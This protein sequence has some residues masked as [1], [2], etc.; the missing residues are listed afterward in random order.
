MKYYITENLT[1]TAGVRDYQFTI[2]GCH[3]TLLVNGQVSF[4]LYNMD[5]TVATDIH[6]QLQV[7]GTLY[8]NI[9]T[10]FYVKPGQ[11][12]LN[13]GGTSQLSG[14]LCYQKMVDSNDINYKLPDDIS[15]DISTG[16]ANSIYPANGRLCTVEDVFAEY[17]IDNEFYD[18]GYYL[19]E[20]VKNQLVTYEM[21]LKG[22]S[23]KLLS[24]VGYENINNN[25]KNS[26]FKI[27]KIDPTLSEQE[28]TPPK[29]FFNEILNA[30]KE[31]TSK[32]LS[33]NTTYDI[34]RIDENTN[35]YDI[36]SHTLTYKSEGNNPIITD[37]D[38]SSITENLKYNKPLT[39]ES[40]KE[41]F[42]TLIGNDAHRPGIQCSL[43]S[44]LDYISF[45][46][47][48]TT[49]N[50]GL[51]TLFPNMLETQYKTHQVNNDMQFINVQGTIRNGIL[52][53]TFV[54]HGPLTDNGKNV[55]YGIVETI[56]RTQ[57]QNCTFTIS[58]TSNPFSN[59]NDIKK[60]TTSFYD[61]NGNSVFTIR[62]LYDEIYVPI[63]KSIIS[64]L[65]YN[66][67]KIYT[68]PFNGSQTYNILDRTG[69]D[70]AI[71]HNKV[72]RICDLANI[73]FELYNVTSPMYPWYIGG[74]TEGDI[75]NSIKKYINK[76]L[77]TL[78]TQNIE[79]NKIDTLLP[80]ASPYTYYNAHSFSPLWKKKRGAK[81]LIIE[82]A[83]YSKEY[84]IRS[85]TPNV[86]IF[87]V[88]DPIKFLV[89][90]SANKPETQQ[91]LAEIGFTLDNNIST[92]IYGGVHRPNPNN[93]F[94]GTIGGDDGGGDD[95]FRPGGWVD[96]WSGR[97]GGGGGSGS[98]LGGGGNLPPSST[99]DRKKAEQKQET[100]SIT[101]D[102]I[103]N[104]VNNADRTKVEYYAVFPTQ[105]NLT[106]N[107][108]RIYTSLALYDKNDRAI[109]HNVH[110]F[111]I[112]QLP[113]QYVILFIF[114]KPIQGN[115]TTTYT[116]L[117]P[118]DIQIEETSQNYIIDLISS[119]TLKQDNTLV[120]YPAIYKLFNIKCAT[121]N[122]YDFNFNI[123]I[124]KSAADLKNIH[125]KTGVY[126]KGIDA[127]GINT[128][129]DDMR[130]V[131]DISTYINDDKTM[132][133]DRHELN[134][135]KVIVDPNLPTIS[136]N[137]GYN[138]ISID[139]KINTDMYTCNIE[140]LWPIIEN[141]TIKS[142]ITAKFNV[143]LLNNQNN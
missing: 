134:T 2:D 56:E 50:N 63:W 90:P 11:Y 132:K 22:L 55:R 49:T 97:D 7:E 54:G 81:N 88:T 26:A 142:S 28:Q 89:D 27:Y 61:N 21:A 120:N 19:A 94:R 109:T 16:L 45:K 124:N 107:V 86:K 52:T 73:T 133:L 62:K 8:A 10:E 92:G 9:K 39:T 79:R 105:P 82:Y 123:N 23:I 136:G 137:M 34:S 53:H 3:I 13:I 71:L 101:P 60:F 5:N 4:V 75:E 96:D 122:K 125:Y 117:N 66:T 106:P 110:G 127:T 78:D 6:T 77:F 30:I 139:G 111:S 102:E 18:N 100:P 93:N 121:G 118:D 104:K 67:V 24:V 69:R 114:Y 135:Y 68:T 85:N 29:S 131:Y 32:I 91:K 99:E 15:T 116:T 83:Q 20:H 57:Q 43:W 80:T 95:N 76:R 64:D 58:H 33:N 40:Q 128:I 129:K 25:P 47:Q 12:K 42:N 113:R 108:N 98:G 44:L 130:N 143:Q 35:I 17:H 119:G 14:K 37:T 138:K 70:D 140:Q 65:I 74:N 87:Q 36:L 103:E 51:C 1:L 112:Y 84:T 31:W 48:F 72:V 38:L 126:F 59:D 141:N 115:G 46:Y 41:I